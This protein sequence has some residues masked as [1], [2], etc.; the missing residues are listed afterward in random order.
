MIHGANFTGC[1]TSI[2]SGGCG[3]CGS[4]YQNISVK[5]NQSQSV[6]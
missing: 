5:T 4:T 6:R 1:R 3:S 2:I